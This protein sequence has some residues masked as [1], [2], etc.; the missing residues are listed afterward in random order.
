M[1]RTALV[2]L[3]AIPTSEIRGQAN[4]R[5]DF[6]HDVLPVLRRRCASCHTNGQAKGGLSMDTRAALLEA[7]AIEPGDAAASI[8]IERVTEADPVLRMPPKGPAL[9]EAEVATLRRWIDQ[10]AAWQ[11]GFSFATAGSGL[12]LKPRRPELPP[13][14][15]GRTHPID[16]LVD[17]YF[18][19]HRVAPPEPLGDAA[20]L[21]RVSLDLV[22]LLPTPGRLEAFLADAAPDKRERAVRELLGDDQ[23]YAEHWLTF[24]N[25]LLRNDYE[26]TGYIDGG[27]KAITPWLYRALR[28]NMPY[29]RF[30]REL[31]S[32]TPESEG[33]IKGIKWRGTV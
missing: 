13:A 23:A 27:R 7:E 6:A 9:S 1:F 33:F 31:I 14:R 21:R 26:G 29:D 12:P 20:F 4:E 15:A 32:P 17:A 24:W 5:V 19:A 28:E 8:L 30:V 11:E 16:R 10:G 18:A 25:D 3:L 2:L 22:G